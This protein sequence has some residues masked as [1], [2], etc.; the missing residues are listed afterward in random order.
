MLRSVLPRFELVD[1]R[2]IEAL[3]AALA[4]QLGRE[5]ASSGWVSSPYAE[6]HVP[7]AERHLWSPCLQISLIPLEQGTALR[8]TFR[9]EPAVW[10]GF[11]FAHSVC[12]TVVLVGLC[13]ALSQW[14]LGHPPSALIAALVGAS[15]SLGLYL[16]ALRG[17]ALGHDQMQALR[18]QLERALAAD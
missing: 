7:P 18:R 2:S 6:L 11:V 1:P 15:C 13:L 4:A 17:H 8:C 5:D 16:G 3:A 14:T 9:P 10:T 12:A